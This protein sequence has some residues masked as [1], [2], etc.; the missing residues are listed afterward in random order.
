[1]SLRARRQRRIVLLGIVCLCIQP[2]WRGTFISLQTT[3]PIPLAFS[4][5]RLNKSSQSKS[6][7][8]AGGAV[9]G[10]VFY[11]ADSK[12]RWR[13]ARYYIKDRKQG[14]LAEAIVALSSK[15]LKLPTTSAK[16]TMLTM[17]QEDFR[18]VPETMAIRAGDRIKFTNSDGVIH[19]VR[20]ND[21]AQPFNINMAAGGGFTR[22][23]QRAGGTR[24]P[25]RLGCVFHSAMRG[26]IFVFDHPY[27]LVTK[28]DGRFRID[29]V[30]PGRYQLEMVHPAGSLAWSK[31]IVVRK[32]ETTSID[33]RVSPDHLKEKKQ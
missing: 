29:N 2:G 27:Y 25:I 26:W 5:E 18:F 28:P 30:P 11:L 33:I 10:S 16:P 12:R 4:A 13:Y 3:A 20:T 22:K 23:F 1:M 8:Q 24:R 21:G 7:G 15:S 6:A 9:E 14:R 31:T 19:N 17:D 32:S